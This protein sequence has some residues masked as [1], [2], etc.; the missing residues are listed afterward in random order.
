MFLQYLET[1]TTKDGLDFSLKT[2]DK[3]KG[4]TRKINGQINH[5]NDKKFGKNK[6]IS[7]ENAEIY[8]SNHGGDK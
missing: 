3:F 2:L 4:K 7:L 8:S 1:K 6:W 5:Q